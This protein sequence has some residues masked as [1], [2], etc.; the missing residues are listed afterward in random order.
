MYRIAVADDERYV[1]E[2]VANLLMANLDDIEVKTANSGLDVLE[3]SKSMIFD[4]AILDICMPQIDGITVAKQLLEQYPLC[5]IILLTG[6]DEFNLIYQ[7]NNVKNITYALKTE[8]D[9]TILQRV[10][11]AIVA[12]TQEQLQSQILGNAE[13]REL[14]LHY[15]E[16]RDILYNLVYGAEHDDI[17]RIEGYASL[18]SLNLRAPI[19]LI[20]L[21]FPQDEKKPQI[22]SSGKI[23][24]LCQCI[25]QRMGFLL[26]YALLDIDRNKVIIFTQPISKTQ[27]TSVLSLLQAELEHICTMFRESY[28]IDLRYFIYEDGVKL[29]Q[30]FATIDILLHMSR[31]Y[32]IDPDTP[33]WGTIC[34][35]HTVVEGLSLTSN[36]NDAQKEIQKN[37]LSLSAAFE[38]YSFESANQILENISQLQPLLA[39]LPPYLQSQIRTE[40]ARIF[41]E[42]IDRFQLE[43][44]LQ[45][46]I[47]FSPML[48]SPNHSNWDHLFSYYHRLLRLI[49]EYA[50]QESLNIHDQL[51]HAIKC[52]ITEHLSGDLSI[53][54]LSAQFGYNQSYISRIFKQV[55]KQAL[56]QFI[57]LERL[58]RAKELLRCTTLPIREIAEQTG[59]GTVQ[60]F[61]MTF[62]KEIGITP[63]VYRQTSV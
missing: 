53:T 41:M 40:L 48:H 24:S 37:L 22:I 17:T 25:S 36:H 38:Q 27:E 32:D 7:V 60:Y 42:Y 49:R 3:M 61:T 30:V 9:A 59:F 50:V 15:F 19:Y 23:V 47:S 11:D 2:W 57:K 12:I 45:R 44:I 4:I 8:P 43:N 21:D 39:Q 58:A 52:Y 31:S 28:P 34:H 16:Q 33:V 51:V 14:L 46:H 35:C 18:V 26:H 54:N 56:S 55:T 29:E 10:S 13:R 5:R 62:R 63:K 6:H 20:L 1:V